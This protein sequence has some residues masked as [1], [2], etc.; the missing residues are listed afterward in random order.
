MQ[1]S[2]MRNEDTEPNASERVARALR[3]AIARGRF[4]AGERMYQDEVA[5]ALG[6]SR[7]PVR[8]AFQRLQA[9][10]LLTEVRSGRLIVT[11]L[12]PEEV[13]DNISIRL[14][15]EPH[16]A[17]LAAEKITEE[18]IEE[19]RR[20]NRL[21]RE[22]LPNKPNWNYEFHKLLAVASGS[23]IL[24]QF[25]DRLWASMPL[26]PTTGALLEDTAERSTHDHDEMI[27]CLVRRDG[28]GVEALMRAHIGVTMA[29]HI[30]RHARKHQ[31]VGAL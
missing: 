27:E 9:E 3:E 24:A 1:Q 7:Q 28:P 15:L 11:K 30:R 14:L 17:R 5:E 26:R 4:Q 2:V 19:L 21:I 13:I 29:F 8:Q 23:K 18:Q 22:D 12:S 10:G 16:A 25:I 6:V 20:Y 31:E